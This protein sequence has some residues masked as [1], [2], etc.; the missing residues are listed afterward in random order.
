MR[1]SRPNNHGCVS[2]RLVLQPVGTSHRRREAS[3]PT[4]SR[5]M[6]TPKLPHMDPDLL[7]LVCPH[8]NTTEPADSPQE[9]EEPSNRS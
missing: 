1:R 2:S 7:Q 6:M 5:R 9:E 4:S 3:H 8:L